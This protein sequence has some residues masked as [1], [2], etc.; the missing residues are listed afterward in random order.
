MID[1]LTVE[2]KGFFDGNPLL[3]L[4]LTLVVFYG[5]QK[6]YHKLNEIPLLH[7]VLVSIVIIIG[8]LMIFDIDYVEYMQG[9]QLVHFFLGP[10]TVALAWP[11]YQHID[12][13]KRL[14]FP[15]LAHPYS[16]G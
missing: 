14:W 13:I 1:L 5:S 16:N 4:L 7:P 8:T 10:A 15:C 6:L 3:G 11:L 2:I 12:S 9:G